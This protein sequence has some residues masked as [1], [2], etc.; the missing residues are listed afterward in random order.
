MGAGRA[1]CLPA[2][3]PR[4]AP[5]GPRSPLKPLCRQEPRS[6]LQRR[7][8]PEHHG[9][10]RPRARARGWERTADQHSAAD[11]HPHPR[12]ACHN[13]HRAGLRDL[14]PGAC[15]PGS[16]LWRRPSG[17]EWPSPH[18]WHVRHGISRLVQHT[19]PRGGAVNR[20]GRHQR[21]TRGGRARSNSQPY[22]AC[23]LLSSAATLRAQVGHNRR[24]L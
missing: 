16:R 21:G 4:V 17:G 11:F 2:V 9:Q 3:A 6:P 7:I 18:L 23:Q 15:H 24:P 1:S 14:W 22:A 13:Q 5:P 12:T 10:L 8:R 20:Q 19:D